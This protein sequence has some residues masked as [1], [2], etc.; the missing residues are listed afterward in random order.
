[1]LLD[2]AKEIIRENP[3]DMVKYSVKYFENLLKE[4]GYFDDKQT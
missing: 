3:S 1:M 4:S 2:Y